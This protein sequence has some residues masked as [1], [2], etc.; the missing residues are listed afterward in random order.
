ME[1]MAKRHKVGVMKSKKVCPAPTKADAVQPPTSVSS[2]SPV[3]TE[4]MTQLSLRVHGLDN[5]ELAGQLKH[6]KSVY[7]TVQALNIFLLS[8]SDV[9]INSSHRLDPTSLIHDAKVN[10]HLE[11]LNSSD[12]NNFIHVYSFLNKGRHVILTC[13]YS[14]ADYFD[15]LIRT[16]T[17]LSVELD[18]HIN[19]EGYL[20]H[21]KCINRIELAKVIDKFSR[22]RALR[23]TNYTFDIGTVSKYFGVKAI[24]QR[25]AIDLLGGKYIDKNCIT[26]TFIINKIAFKDIENKQEFILDGTPV[27]VFITDKQWINIFNNHDIKIAKGDR[28]KAKAIIER[29]PLNNKIV[30]YYFVEIK[31]INI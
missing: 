31:G 26:G 8:C 4:T 7:E 11:I 2:T 9:L 17:E 12:D 16:L 1:K 22:I 27:N 5:L 3:S 28:I 15:T 20:C 24:E 29:S 13:D 14:S 30:A 6:V 19:M 18:E 25:K 23:N 21:N 10:V